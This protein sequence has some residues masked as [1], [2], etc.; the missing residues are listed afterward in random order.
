M[1]PTLAIVP[2]LPANFL[3]P[4]CLVAFLMA[5]AAAFRAKNATPLGLALGIGVLSFFWSRGAITL[6]SYGLFLV[7]GFFLSV[8]LACVEAKR[9][10][11]DPNILLDMAMPLLLV[12]ILCCRILYFVVYPG[13]WQG[14][15]Q[16][17]QIWNG[18]LSFHGAFV[19]AISVIAYFCWSRKISFFSLADIIVPGALAGYAIGRIGCL[20]NGCCYGHECNLPWAV[21]FQTE[22][23]RAILT[24]P[25]HPA[26]AYSTILSLFLF[27]ILWK[28]RLNPRWNRFPGQLTLIFFAFYAFERFVVEIFRNGATAPLAFGISWLTMA[29]LVSVLAWLV[30]G[31]LYW[32]L[33]RRLVF[34][35]P[36]NPDHVSAG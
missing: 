14:I 33:S 7:L 11:V 3:I 4:I 28:M 27:A 19:G 13:Q 2:A 25:S 26:Q 8:Y 23:N 21:Q 32:F 20:F 1:R 30:I 34:S 36:K 9:R 29:Q 12:S 35:Q 5:G 24:A 6:H 15:G 10:G 16:F 17:F 31:A 22:G 18:G